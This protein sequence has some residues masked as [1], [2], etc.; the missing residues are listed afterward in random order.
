MTGKKNISDERL[1]ESSANQI[2]I[3]EDHF[4]TTTNHF[5]PVGP[6][7]RLSRLWHRMRV[8]VI[9]I[10]SFIGTYKE[11]WWLCHYMPPGWKLTSNF[12]LWL[13]TALA[14][15]KHYPAVTTRSIPPLNAHYNAI[16]SLT[17]IQPQLV[18]IFSLPFFARKMTS[19]NIINTSSKFHT[20]FGL[21]TLK[22]LTSKNNL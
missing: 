13:Q 2:K 12:T 17:R 19:G 5:L 4:S 11:F 3:F 14:W 7:K 18:T 1:D 22:L 16:N 9:K 8:S 21:S 6:A 15:R 20:W 10:L